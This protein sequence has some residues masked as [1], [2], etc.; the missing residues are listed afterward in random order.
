MKDYYRILGVSPDTEDVVIRAAWKALVQRYHPDRVGGDAA[1]AN[2]RIVEIN[3]A[4]NVL[5]DADKRS[6]YD[7]ARENEEEN[8]DE[9]ESVN[10][11][12][13]DYEFISPDWL[14]A[15]KQYPD[16]VTIN[17]RLSKISHQLAF[18]FRARML[19]SDD[20]LLFR[21]EVAADIE[22]EF[23]YLHFGESAAINDLALKLIFAGNKAAVKALNEMFTMQGSDFS[24]EDAF[25]KICKDF[26]F[27]T[28]QM[29]EM[30]LQRAREKS[31]S[32]PHQKKYINSQSTYNEDEITNTQSKSKIGFFDLA[33]FFGVTLAPYIFVWFLLRKG[34]GKT[35]RVLGFAYLILYMFVLMYGTH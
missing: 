17:Q 20:E 33:L 22:K 1:E 14:E 30:R 19:E 11:E 7:N 6:A 2:T 25:N 10:D 34:Y 21:Q 5:S 13:V 3:E 15:V 24:P 9:N 32:Q 31:E 26:N 8:I 23:M 35:V 29:R 16:L 4:Y 27:E 18:I 12:E 28:D